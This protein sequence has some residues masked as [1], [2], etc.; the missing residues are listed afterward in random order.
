MPFDPSLKEVTV[1][2]SGPAPDI[3]INNPQGMTD[4][5]QM[6]LDT[7]CWTFL[8]TSSLR[9]YDNLNQKL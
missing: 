6:A 3:E 4:V 7:Q 9:I 1:A 5:L 8:Q 2:L